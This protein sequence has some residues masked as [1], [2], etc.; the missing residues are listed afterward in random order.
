MN[1]RI[2]LSICALL[3]VLVAGPTAL[4][5]E[6]MSEEQA[7]RFLANLATTC[8]EAKSVSSI[9]TC[10]S[11]SATL[12]ESKEAD[13]NKKV[14]KKAIIEL[15]KKVLFGLGGAIG[16]G[17]KVFLTGQEIAGEVYDVGGR[18]FSD[19]ESTAIAMREMSTVDPETFKKLVNGRP[20]VA[21]A[22]I[23]ALSRK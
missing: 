8:S 14:G 23:T 4:A 19:T 15:A 22:L 5:D 17:V 12:S 1:S 16:G 20:E 3:G 18:G 2:V 6:E 7:T 9:A 10:S 11:V 13:G 21:E